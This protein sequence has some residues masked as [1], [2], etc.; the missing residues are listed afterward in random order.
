M[1]AMSIPPLGPAQA[2]LLI[3]PL[4]VVI[5]GRTNTAEV[6][7]VNTSQDINTYRLHWQQ[8]DQ[9]DIEGGY[10]P[11]DETTRETRTDLEDFAIFTPR[12]ITLGPDEKQ[13][14][15]LTV[16]R[17]SNLAEGE[18]KS[19]L[20][21][22]IVPSLTVKKGTKQAAKN[23]LVSAP[24]VYTSYAIPILY[25]PNTYDAAFEISSPEF[26]I[27]KD[28]SNI[29]IKTIISRYGSHGAVGLIEIFHRPTGEEE[30]MIGTLGNASVFAE[31]KSRKF[32]IMT[33]EKSIPPGQLRIVYKK[34]E[35]GLPSNYP[36]LKKETF[37]INP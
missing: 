26:F 13:T 2:N 36:T 19:H 32:T 29:G 14:I 31:I 3:T 5:G 21:F 20:K 33:Q 8:L 6:I 34:S 1:A 23:E 7:L 16:R 15:S 37:H 18:Y 30:I 22:S 11:I 27:N 17:P 9:V 4:Q 35:N 12:Q 24:I 25:R 10:I 28:T